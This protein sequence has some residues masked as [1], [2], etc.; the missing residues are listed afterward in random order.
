MGATDPV[1][2]ILKRSI[3]SYFE[4][5]PYESIPSLSKKTGVSQPTIR[6]LKK[7]ETMN[8][9]NPSTFIK[10]MNVTSPDKEIHELIQESDE[11]CKQ[12]LNQHFSHFNHQLESTEGFKQ[13][14]Q[15]NVKFIV[16]TLAG[17]HSGVTKEEVQA[18]YGYVGILA[19]VD[20]EKEDFIK[21]ENNKWFQ[22]KEKV[23]MDA[24]KR[25]V[26]AITHLNEYI[27][28]KMNPFSRSHSKSQK[29]S[30]AG[31]KKLCK[32][33]E[34]FERSIEKIMSDEKNFGDVPMF[35]VSALDVLS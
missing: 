30:P 31:C 1:N 8:K 23:D 35:S 34:A 9:P 33:Q 24:L 17:H 16:L 18:T 3:I 28:E 19:M 13:L 25:S 7:G 6:K 11:G 15:D 20:L 21:F 4:S 22:N 12:Y 2:D 10:I 26:S 5:H 27:D 29:M 14:L 32:A